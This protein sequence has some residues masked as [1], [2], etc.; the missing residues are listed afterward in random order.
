MNRFYKLNIITRIIILISITF[1][2][3]SFTFAY[4]VKTSIHKIFMGEEVVTILNPKFLRDC[5]PK[6]QSSPYI[7]LILQL[8][9]IRKTFYVSKNV[10]SKLKPQYHLKMSENLAKWQAFDLDLMHQFLRNHH[11]DVIPF[12]RS[13][14]DVNIML[15]DHLLKSK[16]KSKSFDSSSTIKAV[17]AYLFLLES[18][19][20][21]LI[22]KMI[23][24]A[25]Q[26]KLIYTFSYLFRNNLLSEDETIV[27]HKFMKLLQNNKNSYKSAMQKDMRVVFR[28]YANVYVKYPVSSQLLQ[29][30]YGDPIAQYYKLFNQSNFFTDKKIMENPST[31]SK[32]H[33]YVQMVSPNGLR[34]KEKVDEI[35]FKYLILLE[36]I[37]RRLND[38]SRDQYYQELKI[39]FVSNNDNE[40]SLI[41]L[42][43]S[44]THILTPLTSEQVFKEIRY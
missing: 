11:Q 8:Q 10:E 18:C 27:L 25:L 4:N 41:D 1:F 6:I 32:L 19:N 20:G 17:V 35:E 14:R 2:V 9:K 23:S 39:Q 38:K 34:A 31:F 24:T 22:S 3:L 42:K 7:A 29:W 26:K 13:A 16:L 28:M 21:V 44:K 15:L 43:T 30:M 37:R 36:Q 33:P 12:Y 5:G 40:I